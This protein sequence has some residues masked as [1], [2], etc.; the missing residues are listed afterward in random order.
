MYINGKDV[1]FDLEDI[2][3][4][5]CFELGSVLYGST[6]CSLFNSTKS[7]FIDTTYHKYIC[8]KGIE[9]GMNT[10][11][12]VFNSN[13]LKTDFSKIDKDKI[14]LHVSFKTSLM[15]IFAQLFKLAKEKYFISFWMNYG[16]HVDFL[17]IMSYFSEKTKGV[18]SKF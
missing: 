13:D 17:V 8:L 15:D 10:L 18:F 16:S 1:T 7:N 9:I 2:A 12:N 5:N 3:V 11:K 14:I 6:V 4:M